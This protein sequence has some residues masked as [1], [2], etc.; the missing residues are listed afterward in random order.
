LRG[1]AHHTPLHILCSRGCVLPVPNG[2]FLFAGQQ[3]TDAMAAYSNGAIQIAVKK[4]LAS[5]ST[6]FERAYG[7]EPIRIRS[8][9]SMLTGLYPL[10]NGCSIVPKYG[11]RRRESIVG[12]ARQ[13]TRRR[14]MGIVSL[15]GA[16]INCRGANVAVEACGEEVIDREL[17]SAFQLAFWPGTQALM[18]TVL[19]QVLTGRAER[20]KGKRREWSPA[21]LW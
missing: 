17:K 18:G 5:E 14:S 19:R 10:T 8:G 15:S 13:V 4:R 21:P 11:I 7:M 2:H 6:V 20:E 12:R 3:H 1:R 9:S 16:I